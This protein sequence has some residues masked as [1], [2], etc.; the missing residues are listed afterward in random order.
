MN[1][2]NS[3]KRVSD[4]GILVQ[5][6]Q[7]NWSEV[8][9]RKNNI[10]GKFVGGKGPYLQKMGVD[11]AMGQAEFVSPQ[12]IRVGEETYEAN[13]FL[14]G[15]GSESILPPFE[16][17]EHGITSKELLFMEQL[18]KSMVVIGGG[19]IGMEFAHIFASA[20][21]KVT[22][23]QRGERVLKGEDHETSRVIE[24]I[25]QKMGIDM[26]F[27]CHVTK[28]E[29][30]GQLRTVHI[31]GPE[32]ESQIEA[33][34]VLIAT[35][36]KPAVEGLNL[37]AAGVEYSPRGIQVND[38][39]Q[40]TAE[41]IYAAGDSIGGYMFTP[42]AAHQAKVAVRNAL[43]GN[44]VKPDYRYMTRAVFTHPPIGSVGLTEEEARNEGLDVA[45]GKLPYA[46]SGT[47]IL[48]GETE[49]Q[50]KVI[51]DKK[52]RQLVG[53]HFVG[54]DADELIHL[55]TVA[56]KGKLTVDD[57]LEIIP[58]HPTLAESLIEMVRGIEA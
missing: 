48:L 16:G 57:F 14:I 31:N 54:Q 44:R 28:I 35:G 6:P 4:F 29:K 2:W 40:T 49:G 47:A 37:S 24:D 46:L 7:L 23:L 26:K 22:L 51:V 27:R 17:V 25:S 34:V 20:G 21:T 9:Q 32:G 13:R 56:M 15:V 58:V 30:Q 11:L 12:A 43:K 1:I 36:R 52:T 53:A 41:R 10:I 55:V 5:S 19:I 39:L 50:M 33:E 45:V 8:V 3:I 18:P 38:Y 42:I